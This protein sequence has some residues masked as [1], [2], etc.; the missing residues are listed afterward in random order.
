M[1][2]AVGD[3]T[4]MGTDLLNTYDEPNF[5]NVKWTVFLGS[6]DP[7]DACHG[8]IV[9]ANGL[10]DGDWLEAGSLSVGVGLTPEMLSNDIQLAWLKVQ[11]YHGHESGHQN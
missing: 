9:F 11:H 2:L 1:I 10:T 5:L 7:L 8:S 4:T 3:D 6:L